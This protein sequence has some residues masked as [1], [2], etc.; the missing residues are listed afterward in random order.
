MAAADKALRE[1]A[2]KLP[3]YKAIC[4]KVAQ[5]ATKANYDDEIVVMS[6]LDDGEITTVYKPQP[7][8][9]IGN[10]DLHFDAGR[11]LFTSHVDPGELTKVPNTH[12]AKGYG[13][14][15][16][17]IDPKTGHMLGKPHRVS[18]DMGWDV[19]NFD[20]CYLPDGRIIFASTA[21]YDGVPCVG[22][23]DHVANL[24][25]MN[26]DGT[27]VRRLTFDQDG[28]WHPTMMENGR[29]MYTRWEY[30]DSAH[31]YLSLIHISEPTRR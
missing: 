19:D 7:G 1:A 9:F 2:N 30:T 8:K 28:N 31:Y 10:V 16:L 25:I 26:S 17:E 12:Q 15:E 6:P 29:V 11:M 24:Y 18:P 27:G 3:E 20:P 22:G 4:T 14:F 23:K 21:A 5:S 13:V